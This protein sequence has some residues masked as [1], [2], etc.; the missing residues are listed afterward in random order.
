[1]LTEIISMQTDCPNVLD[2]GQNFFSSSGTEKLLT[3]IAARVARFRYAPHEINLRRAN[4]NS[5]QSVEKLAEILSEA[6]EFKKL[7]IE[8]Q[9]GNR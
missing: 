8:C 6:V 7:S 5:D 1:M 2:L 4:F 9:Q 3:T